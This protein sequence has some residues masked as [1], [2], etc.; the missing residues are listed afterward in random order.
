MLLDKDVFEFLLTSPVS[1]KQ[2]E[3]QNSEMNFLGMLG[4]RFKV[5]LWKIKQE[6]LKFVDKA[7][8]YVQLLHSMN[9]LRSSYIV[10]HQMLLY[11]FLLQCCM[12]QHS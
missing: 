4:N 10:C 2:F 9:N 6:W 12:L 5:H 1:E 8:A 3:I 7:K 11:V